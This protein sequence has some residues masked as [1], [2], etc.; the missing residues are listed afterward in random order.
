MHVRFEAR[1]GVLTTMHASLRLLVTK[2]LESVDQTRVLT[3]H[4]DNMMYICVVTVQGTV[5]HRGYAKLA[6][7][8]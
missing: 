8:F 6:R 2:L 1:S 5:L 7:P 4:V 3:E